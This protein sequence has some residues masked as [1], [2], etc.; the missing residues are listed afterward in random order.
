MSTTQP[1]MIKRIR[2]YPA[3]AVIGGAVGLLIGYAVTQYILHVT[4][5]K[6][7][8]ATTLAIGF[9]SVIASTTNKHRMVM[10]TQQELI[11]S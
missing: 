11:K 10:N 6:V 3:D 8:V 7:L 5:K 2:L 4:D 9:I 1:N